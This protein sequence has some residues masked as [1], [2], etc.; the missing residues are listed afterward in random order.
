M[1]SAK[2]RPAHLERAAYV[3]IRQ[4]TLTQVH[5]NLESQRRQYAFADYARSLGWARVEVVDDDLG[6]SGSGRAERPGFQRVVSAMCLEEVGGV[7]AL[8]ASRLAR[9]NRDWHHLVDLC[10]L[11]STLLIDGDGIYD[12]RDFNDRLLLGLKGTMS[13]WELGVMRQRS[14]EALRQKAERGELYT[15]VPIG[16]LRTRDDRCELDPDRRIQESLRLIFEKFEELGSMR[17]VLLWFRE[18][19]VEVPAVEYGP[20]GRSVVWKLPVYNSVHNVL[21]NPI[22]AGA[23]A[24]GRTKTE[25]S[26]TGGSAYRRSGITVPQE[27]WAVLIPDHHEGY[28]DWDAYQANQK[29]I[30]EN[31]QMKG[32][33]SR[34]A[35]RNGASLLAGLLR[36]RRCGRRLHVTYTGSA[37]RVVRY[38]C[39]GA[40]INHGAGS[41]IGFGGLAVDRAVEQAIFS[42]IEPGAIEAALQASE[43]A[44]AVQRRALEVLDLKLEQA[45]YET[46]RARRQY[47]AVDPENRLVAAE[48]ERRWNQ[49]L[50]ML[51]A[52]EREHAVLESEGEK[53]PKTIDREALLQLAE[54]LPEVWHDAR[55]DMRLKKRIVRTLIEEILV[56]VDEEA[57]RV[58]LIVRWAGGLHSRLSVKKRRPGQ[59]RHTTDRSVVKIVRELATLLPDGQIARVLNRLGLR[60]GRGNSWNQG[61]VVSLRNY[62]RIPVYNAQAA[63]REGLLTL[64][65]AAAALDVSPTVVRKL[66]GRGILAG[67][68]VVP[69]APWI[70]RAQDLEKAEV[71]QYVRRVQEGK[72]RPQT[73]DLEQ[74]SVIDTDT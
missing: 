42:V 48:L 38:S 12:P 45:R 1:N 8:E 22:Y 52:L 17:Q 40:A 33:M 53:G 67:R 10:G 35:P 50:E 39:R 62:N 28:I 27:K 30:G 70:I 23:Y 68:Q 61:R 72:N 69:Y 66:L 56:D 34:G 60:T 65:Q 51:G 71:Q 19:K 29:R 9:N 16:F 54:D 44:K 55:A 5:E 63:E 15:T 74:L 32:L 58:Q 57:S 46:E 26:V 21:T 18:E 25:T 24:Y 4:S 47:H 43:D 59:H 64:E 14:L 13:E 3:Y 49:A 2:I 31:A 7:F 37:G 11:T 73:G 6:R 41:C 36:C 20:F